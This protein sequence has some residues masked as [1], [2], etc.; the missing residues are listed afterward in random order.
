MTRKDTIYDSYAL[1]DD[2]TSHHRRL[3]VLLVDDS[4]ERRNAIADA[5]A[6]VSCEVI[7]F[8]SDQDDVLIRVQ[9][10]NPDV[11]IVDLESPGRDTLDSLRSV[12]SITPRPIVM[13]SQDDH[14][15]TIARATRAGVSAYVVDGLSRK[16]VRPIL[17]A[18]IQRFQQFR[19][20]ADEL[21]KTRNEL[22]ERKTLDK[23]KKLLM[24]QRGM[25]EE[26]AYKALRSQAMS[27]NKRLAEVAAIVV[28]AA[29][30]LFRD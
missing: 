2:D 25:S 17:D 7:G 11:V 18:A 30:I 22:E 8:V 12:Q 15:A 26:E 20:I 14:G 10:C 29:D 28:E 16:R 21:E 13:F 3:R 4:S 23:A 24:K 9:D 5:L 19:G 1:E 27:T 6:E